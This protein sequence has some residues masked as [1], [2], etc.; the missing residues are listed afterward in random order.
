MAWGLEVNHGVCVDM[1]NCGFDK[2]SGIPY[3]TEKPHLQG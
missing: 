3:P 1:E 2:Y